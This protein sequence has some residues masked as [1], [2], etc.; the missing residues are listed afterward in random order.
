MQTYTYS[1]RNYII[2]VLEIK[3]EVIILDGTDNFIYHLQFALDGICIG[4]E[5]LPSTKH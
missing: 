4:R 5:I 3:N 2:I 1:V